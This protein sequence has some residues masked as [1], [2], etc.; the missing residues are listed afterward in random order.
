MTPPLSF[1]Q[2]GDG[3]RIEF[4]GVPNATTKTPSGPYVKLGNHA[5]EETGPGII[6]DVD[7]TAGVNRLDD[8]EPPSL[9]GPPRLNPVV[10]KQAHEWNPLK[11]LFE[12]APNGASYS[13]LWNYVV[14][15]VNWPWRQETL[16]R[17]A[18]QRLQEVGLIAMVE[19]TYRI[20]GAG[21]RRYLADASR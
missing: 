19:S 2:L 14:Q 1:G 4:F 8:T 3:N 9:I 18:L 13:T 11:H 10:D 7:A 16:L 17:A 5:Y 20:T 15:H 12:I 6:R 21:I